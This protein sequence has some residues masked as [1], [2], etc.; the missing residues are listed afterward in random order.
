MFSFLFFLIGLCFNNT[1]IMLVSIC[2]L[3]TNN[4]WY[5]C[6]R[7]NDRIIFFAFNCTFFVF[8]LARLIVKPLTGYYDPYNN[9]YYGLDF[10]N[11]K[12]VLIIFTTLFLSLLFLYIGYF[13]FQGFLL[14]QQNVGK[15]KKPNRSKASNGVFVK[16]VA[17]VS[18]LLFYFTYL[19][20]ILVM[21]D[22]A[23]FTSNL[24]YSQ[25]YSSYDSSFPSWVIKIS[26]MCP[27]ALFVFLATLP[28]KKRSFFPILLFVMSG[29]L[30]LIVGQR[31]NF[32]LNILII[33]VYFVLRNRE[34]KKEKWF[35]KKEFVT[36]VISFPF[37]ILILNAVA[38]IRVDSKYEFSFL[39]SIYEFF[40]SQGVSVNLIGY[41]YSL[42]D[43]LPLGKIYSIGRIIDFL[44][45]NA[46]SHFLFST[47]VFQPQ[48][49]D[50]ALYGNSFA[51]SVS[52]LLSPQRYIK[53]WGYGSCYI[54]EA[55]K[56]LGYFGV[57]LGNFVMGSILALQ[58]Y[59]FRK[60]GI[61]GKWVCLSMTRLLMYA[62]RDTFTSFFVTTF[63]IINIVTLFA[64]LLAA[65]ILSK[66]Y[67][68]LPIKRIKLTSYEEKKM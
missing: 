62:P 38:Y 4:I 1:N 18:E 63:S 9:N 27:S 12:I 65:L 60:K 8:L 39:N 68:K 22:K 49:I 66:Q 20:N 19:F 30:S 50:S 15:P 10:D 44:R 13:L 41:A 2:M 7:I 48:T 59:L 11:Q 5:A 21:I 56:D 52:Y 3:F 31:N 24:G 42:S 14:K 40:Y 51:D 33:L 53:G 25:L 43:Q 35:G 46:I 6:E 58:V 32:V 34:D 23:R 36:A 61:I 16:N 29:V 45:N 47:Q 26:E 57:I 55:Y 67:Y 54:A 17:I 64:I 28:K 37:L